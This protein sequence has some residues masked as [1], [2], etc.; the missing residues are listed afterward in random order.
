MTDQEV[1]DKVVLALR[2]QGRKSTKLNRYGHRTCR[3]RGDYGRKCAAGHLIPDELY[4]RRM[5]QL[6][7]T[8]VVERWPELQVM[9]IPNWLVCDLQAIHDNKPVQNWESCWQELANEHGLTYTPP[10]RTNND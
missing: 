6:G 8:S 3:Y 5:E 4:D 1:F 2:K 10:E 9:A 7:W